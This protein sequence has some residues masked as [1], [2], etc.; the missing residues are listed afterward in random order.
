[1]TKYKVSLI[2]SCGDKDILSFRSEDGKYKNKYGEKIHV[3]TK[4]E[5]IITA[6]YPS[7][8]SKDY[9]FVIEDLV[10]ETKKKE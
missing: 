3:V 4:A 8:I 1:M 7:N 2:D 6:H 5:P 10:K 9:R